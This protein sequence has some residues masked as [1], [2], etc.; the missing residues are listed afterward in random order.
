MPDYT[1]N[2][3]ICKILFEITVPMDKIIGLKPECPHCKKK[4]K[5]FRK[6]DDI[7]V[8][9]SS[10]RTVGT[11]AERNTI[12]TSQDEQDYINAKNTA[13]KRQPFTGSL[14]EGGSLYPVNDKGERVTK[15]RKK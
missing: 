1:F 4:G 10:P 11:L 9:D 7:Y 14:P 3:E 12:R 8:Y 15:G 13:Y 2:C 5:V 6:Y